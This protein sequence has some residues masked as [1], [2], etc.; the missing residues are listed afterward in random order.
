MGPGTRM[1]K[2]LQIGEFAAHFP[3]Y[4]KQRTPSSAQLTDGAVVMQG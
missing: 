4:R 2:Q 1:E 3:G